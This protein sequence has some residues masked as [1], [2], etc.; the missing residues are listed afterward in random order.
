[1]LHG[2]NN[3]AHSIS[4]V[5]C[6]AGA[7]VR[8]STKQKAFARNP[9]N[10]TQLAVEIRLLDDRISDLDS[11]RTNPQLSFGSESDASGAQ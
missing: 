6:I 8:F 5:S 3:R 11:G 10:E 1:M 2:N 9:S 4:A 7:E